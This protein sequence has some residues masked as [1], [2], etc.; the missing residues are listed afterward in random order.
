MA[1]QR[2][3]EIALG[4]IING[5]TEPMS[6]LIVGAYKHNESYSKNMAK[7]N[8]STFSYNDLEKCAVAL[9]IKQHDPTNSGVKLFSNKKTVADRII[10]KIESHFDEMC[11]E[12]NET[13]RNKFGDVQ[14][15]LHCFLCLQG[16][17][18]CEA[19]AAKLEGYNTFVANKPVGFIWLCRGCRVKNDLNDTNKKKAVQ[20]QTSSGTPTTSEPTANEDVT[21]DAQNDANEETED[22][23]SPRRND[24]SSSN[25]PSTSNSKERICPLYAKNQCPHGASGKVKVDGESCPNPHPRKCLKFCRYGNK[26]GRGCQKGRSCSQYHPILCKFSVRNG[27]CKKRECTFTHMRHTK[28]PP[29]H[30][31]IED[32]HNQDQDGRRHNEES[33]PSFNYNDRDFPPLQPRRRRES[34]VSAA[35][36]QSDWFRT[37]FPA[38]GS[39]LPKMAPPPVSNRA[40]T[41]NGK[42][43]V[44]FLVKLIENMKSSFE[45]EISEIRERLP[46]LERFPHPSEN[47]P[48]QCQQPYPI[49]QIPVYPWNPQ[50]HQNS[51]F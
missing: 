25:E 29:V 43:G 8:C 36:S 5:V 31:D 47:L 45:K 35:S 6:K 14:A 22:R 24:L 19:L 16:S 18:N 38:T 11:D 41:N 50:Y 17:H 1:E 4:E 39:R 49:P 40:T 27:E 13:Y 12:C 9:N 15:S 30:R 46:P 3:H 48:Q 28:R 7:I 51:M 37:P 44:D 10:L 34:N 33:R 32:R 23:P 26:R 20:F 2:S 42:L 21:E